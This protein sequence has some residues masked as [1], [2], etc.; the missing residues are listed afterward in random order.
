MPVAVKEPWWTIA[1]PQL[2]AG[3]EE[4]QV[5]YVL[6]VAKSHPVATAAGTLCADAFAR[7]LPPRAWQRLSA[8]AGAKRRWYDWAWVVIDPGVSG[9]RWLL[10][11]RHRRTRLDNERMR[12]NGR[13]WRQFNSDGA[14]APQIC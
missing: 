2:R 14:S 5:S 6:A 9:H 3:I 7:K 11:R 13:D 4:R 10:V 12:Q 8:G 1:D